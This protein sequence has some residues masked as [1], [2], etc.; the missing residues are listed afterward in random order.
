MPSAVTASSDTSNA[1]LLPGRIR[2]ANAGSLDTDDTWLLLGCT[3]GVVRG[4]VG[5][6][7]EL[8]V[9]WAP[10]PPPAGDGGT[11]EAAGVVRG[12]VWCVLVDGA[13]LVGGAGVL[14]LGGGGE[15]EGPDG[16]LLAR[17]SRP[18]R[19]SGTSRPTPIPSSLRWTDSV[20]VACVEV[21]VAVGEVAAPDGEDG[22]SAAMAATTTSTPA[23]AKLNARPKAAR[24]ARAICISPALSSQPVRSAG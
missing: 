18:L 8:L 21:G 9:P 20:F 10:P 7:E 12:W 24:E 14:E 2:L 15:V 13:E 6:R 5:G 16:V 4:R 17:L 11:L 1:V 3:E 23:T 19:L 22:M